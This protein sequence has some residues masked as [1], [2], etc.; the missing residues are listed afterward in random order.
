MGEE[1]LVSFC[2]TSYLW[3]SVFC[4]RIFCALGVKLC[5]LEICKTDML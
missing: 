5:S 4:Y 2:D 3:L 1:L